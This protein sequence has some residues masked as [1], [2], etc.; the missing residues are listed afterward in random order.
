M[1]RRPADVHGHTR[2][3]TTV[4]WSPDGRHLATGGWDER[5]CV[6][7]TGS[8]G[9]PPVASMA[10]D[11]TAGDLAWGA[12][13]RAL[14]VATYDGV[15]A[16]TPAWGGPR[17]TR[18]VGGDS[19]SVGVAWSTEGWLASGSGRKVHVWRD[20]TG[21]PDATLT[22]D[23]EWVRAV[24]WAPKSDRLAIA[25][26]N[27]VRIW[28][29]GDGMVTVLAHSQSVDDVSWSGDGQRLATV[30]GTTLRIW[31]VDDPGEPKVVIDDL[32][33]R[34]T[35]AR[36]SPTGSELAVFSPFGP[37]EIRALD[38]LAAPPRAVLPSEWPT[39]VAWSPGGTTLAVGSGRE[40]VLWELDGETPTAAR[41]LGGIWSRTDEPLGLLALP[42][43]SAGDLAMP[44][45]VR[46]AS[47]TL[48][49]RT[50]SVTDG[51]IPL[52]PGL[53]QVRTLRPDGV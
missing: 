44:V 43:W 32:D 45:E 18:L 35:G 10:V 42:T 53:Y 30:D 17:P 16:W 22:D 40:V 24:A 36:W 3:L 20:L 4:A 33:R 47:L 5:V 25:G 48:V 11:S 46:D 31:V 7:D 28:S 27:G 14:A 29:V 21:I 38:D 12:D 1:A 2:D 23:D 26:R 8:P 52:V 6:W 9:R 34:P 15:Q 41:T 51:P 39:A 19:S 50:T 49:A 13:G 37:V